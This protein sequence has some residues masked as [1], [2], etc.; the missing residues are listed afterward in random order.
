MPPSRRVARALAD[1]ERNRADEFAFYYARAP[2]PEEDFGG[3]LDEVSIYDWHQGMDPR[4]R[5]VS[6]RGLALSAAQVRPLTLVR[7]PT[8]G[9]LEPQGRHPH[10]DLYV[11]TDAIRTQY[12]NQEFAA[13]V[14]QTLEDAGVPT[15]WQSA[16]AA[17]F[18]ALGEAGPDRVLEVLLSICWRL[19]AAGP[20]SDYESRLLQV[21]RWPKPL[22]STLQDGLAEGRPFLHPVILR[23]LILEAAAARKLTGRANQSLHRFP[24]AAPIDKLVKRKP[25]EHPGAAVLRAAFTFQSAWG[26]PAMPSRDPD[27][28][29]AIMALGRIRHAPL[30]QHDTRMLVATR[31][32][33][34]ADEHPHLDKAAK[35]S[36]FARVLSDAAGMTVDEHAS[37][38]GVV[39]LGLLSDARLGDGRGGNLVSRLPVKLR[40]NGLAA[41]QRW[42]TIR[43]NHLSNHAVRAARS[44]GGYEGWGSV[45]KSAGLVFDRFPVV[46]HRGAYHAVGINQLNDA[47]ARLPE[48]LLVEVEG[49][50]DNRVRSHLGHMFAAVMTESTLRL[51][52]TRANLFHTDSEIGPFFGSGTRPDGL[53]SDGDSHLLVE[54]QAGHV[55]E[56]VDRGDP[57]GVR[58]LL[59]R[60]TKKLNQAKTAEQK[61]PE[62]LDFLGRSRRVGM[63]TCLVVIQDPMILNPVYASE[64]DRLGIN[65][66]FYCSAE[67]YE[68]LI[69]LGLKGVGVPSAVKAWQASGV[70]MPL[71]RWLDEHG[72]GRLVSVRDEQMASAA[73]ALIRGISAA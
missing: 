67:E 27:E 12:F 56:R 69:E 19:E 15:P 30:H 6:A 28:L 55:N 50:D 57:I 64:L 22:E 61:L 70:Q 54:F 62:L 29:L 41:L 1:A 73:S 24:E 13:S 23:H 3:R 36:T 51:H 66:R 53:L 8:S 59:K 7:S 49:W 42:L 65:P 21:A 34:L 32:Y 20:C 43:M 14:L 2:W 17:S 72:G 18:R 40:R 33:G 11:P 47:W 52:S 44:A 39:L 71:G 63:S 37:F 16:R 10:L 5:A 45:P 46:R 31:Q 35:P 26:R 68:Y 60:Y 58:L 48:R 9:I 4:W 38:G 25:W